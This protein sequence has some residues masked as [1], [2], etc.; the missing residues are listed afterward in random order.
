MPYRRL[1][2]ISLQRR[3]GFVLTCFAMLVLSNHSPCPPVVEPLHGASLLLLHGALHDVGH[4]VT[5]CITSYGAAQCSRVAAC[6]ALC[7]QTSHGADRVCNDCFAGWQRLYQTDDLTASFEMCSL[8]CFVDPVSH[9]S[10][11]A[12]DTSLY[13]CILLYHPILRVTNGIRRRLTVL[14]ALSGAVCCNTI[15]GS[16]ECGMQ[17]RHDVVI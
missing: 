1:V 16:L 12:Y 9:L 15:H 3:L 4:H 5:C 14:L 13:L 6:P 17:H 2:R 7:K 10:L 11:F 8:H